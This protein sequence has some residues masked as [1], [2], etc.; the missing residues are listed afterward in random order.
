MK[1]VE[2]DIPDRGYNNNEIYRRSYLG[3]NLDKAFNKT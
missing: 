1:S 2:E 3:S